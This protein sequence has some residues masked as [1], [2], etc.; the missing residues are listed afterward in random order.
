MY[1][2]GTRLLTLA[3]ECGCKTV[4]G[5]TMFVGQGLRQFELWTGRTAPRELLEAVVLAEL[6]K[7]QKS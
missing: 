4:E 2:P 6:R 3:H 7:R 5:W 1:N